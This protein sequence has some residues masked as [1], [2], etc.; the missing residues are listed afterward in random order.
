[1]TSMV[2][3][4][5][6]A[7][8]DPL[9]SLSLDFD[10]VFMDFPDDWTSQAI[11]IDDR[12]GR[13]LE[14]D[15]AT[16]L[17]VLQKLQT[18]LKRDINKT[19]AENIA[20]DLVKAITPFLQTRS[21]AV[22]ESASEL[23]HLLVELGN[24]RE[25]LVSLCEACST[26]QASIATKENRAGLVECGKQLACALEQCILAI[27]TNRPSRFL[28]EYTKALLVL[29]SHF[30]TLEDSDALIW[31]M[32]R[33]AASSKYGAISRLQSLAEGE[34]QQKA[35]ADLKRSFV[36]YVAR[37]I[38]KTDRPLLC[39]TIV[40]RYY[41]KRLPQNGSISPTKSREA[42]YPLTDFSRDMGFDWDHFSSAVLHPDEGDDDVDSL[43]EDD[44]A[45]VSVESQGAILLVAEGLC[46][47]ESVPEMAE[48]SFEQLNEC[49]IRYS[50]N[51]TNRLPEV[52]DGLVAM[53]LLRIERLKIS[54]NGTSQVPSSEANGDLILLIQLLSSIAA[55]QPI[56]LIRHAAMLAAESLLLLGS[57]E[58]AH[59]FFVETLTDLPDDLSALRPV[60]IG[61]VKDRI[62]GGDSYWTDE[63]RIA[64]YCKLVFGDVSRD[65]QEQIQAANFA[66]FLHGLRQLAEDWAFIK[67]TRET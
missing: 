2:E 3:T 16:Q 18:S 34:D 37:H 60:I 55:R 10:K 19:S 35:F 12:L 58:L 9:A 14:T 7:I 63:S 45:E 30:A 6:E 43:G 29:S 65:T 13:A 52:T 23:L 28:S 4:G 64:Q 36:S 53:V 47:V 51:V 61:L 44:D 21:Q 49:L 8:D 24:S 66:I 1:M 31:L 48:Y 26:L 39:E 59:N 40:S 27:K 20:W 17:L 25:V 38:G 62:A 50:F 15:E 33:I 22:L 32:Q 56:D 5:K 54:P 67:M 57:N 41:P 46:S 42:L 11:F